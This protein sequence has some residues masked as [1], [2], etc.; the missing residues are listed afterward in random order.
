M[1][2]Q[3][4]EL[5]EAYKKELY[6]LGYNTFSINNIIEDAVNSSIIFEL[7]TEQIQNVISTLEYYIK[8]ANK[9]RS[10]LHK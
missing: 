1:N 3:S 4:I 6:K 5:I 2:A 8:F 7:K 9:C 10:Y